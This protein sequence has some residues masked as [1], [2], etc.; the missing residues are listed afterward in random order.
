M[1]RFK[2]HLSIA[3]NFQTLI[4]EMRIEGYPEVK[5]NIASIGPI[6]STGKEET[7][8]QDMI[9]EVLNLS[10]RDTQ[11]PVDFSIHSTCPRALKMESDNFYDH[12]GAMDFPNPFD[13]MDGR[14]NTMPY[15]QRSMNSSQM[16]HSMSAGRRLLVKIVKGEGLSHAK[17]PYCVVEMDEPPQKNQTGARQ[18]VNPYW[19]EH[20][21][22]DLSNQSSEIL[23]EIYDRPVS[24]NDYPKFLGLGLVGIDELAVGPSSS[25]TIGLQP[26]P[27]ETDP[28]FGAIN[29]EF[30]FIEGAQVPVGRRPYKLKEALKLEPHQQEAMMYAE[31]QHSKMM[32]PS[33]QMSPMRQQLQ[34]HPQQQQSPYMNNGNDHRT[35][36]SNQ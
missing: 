3:M 10:I 8:I 7:E 24:A 11:Y 22:F 16:Q 20:F 36:V 31:Q 34:Q 18:G 26:R 21:L 13:Y 6:K 9:S 19:D 35:M 28:V 30:V 23:F 15:D 29:V 14:D 17:D 27:Y 32:M 12:R 2:G 4:G 1:T 25:Q 33:N 5:I